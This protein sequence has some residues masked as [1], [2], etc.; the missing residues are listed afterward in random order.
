[1]K[2]SSSF[3]FFP[4]L[5]MQKPFLA[6]GHEKQV[7]GQIL[8]HRLQFAHPCSK[9]I[10]SIEKSSHHGAQTS[11]GARQNKDSAIYINHGESKS[12]KRPT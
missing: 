4:R 7:V 2:Y 9:P 3:E 5:K 10:P 8:A 12:S 1:M 6:C 11:Q